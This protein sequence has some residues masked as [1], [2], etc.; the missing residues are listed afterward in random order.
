M[1]A[2]DFILHIS[3]LRRVSRG[4]RIVIGFR[5]ISRDNENVSL[6]PQ[7]RRCFAHSFGTNIC[8]CYDYLEDIFAVFKI[9]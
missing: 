9:S 8:S 3:I 1:P 6:R 4:L 5:G 7:L 2:P